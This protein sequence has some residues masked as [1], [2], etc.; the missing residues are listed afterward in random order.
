IK[1]IITDIT[2]LKT[3]LPPGIFVR[4]GCSR[5]DVLK[6]LIVGPRDTPYELGLFE[7]DMLLPE[8]YPNTNPLVNFRTTGG[9]TASFNPNLYPDGKVCLSLLGTFAGE[10]WNP[11]ESTLLQVLI[12][13][14][15]MVFCEQPFCNEPAHAAAAGS[16]Q[17]AAYN[18]SLHALTLQFGV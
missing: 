5:L 1:S 8:N 4:H 9:G 11:R 15:A 13:I 2:T 7:F 16:L 10:P 12:S 3:S 18:A 14:Q 17:S 6:F